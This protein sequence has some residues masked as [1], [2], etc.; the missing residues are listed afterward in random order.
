M[1]IRVLLVLILALLGS[2][3]VMAHVDSHAAYSLLDKLNHFFLSPDH[4]LLILLSVIA[5]LFVV[6]IQKLKR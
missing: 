5:V 3:P 1:N 2:S 6:T 4:S